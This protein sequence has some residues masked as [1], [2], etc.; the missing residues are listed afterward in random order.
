MAKM[1][2]PTK[3]PEEGIVVGGKKNRMG[4]DVGGVGR[5]LVRPLFWLIVIA[6]LAGAGYY[7]WTKW[8]DHNNKTKDAATK[9]LT[10]AQINAKGEADY[11]GSLK[12]QIDSNDDP[13]KK[14]SYQVELAQEYATKN[15]YSTALK[16]AKEA[17]STKP[18]LA[19]ASA[20]GNIYLDMKDY[21]NA[22]HY[23]TI[24][25]DRAPKPTSSRERS[26]YNDITAQIE[27]IK[28]EQNQ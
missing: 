24:A 21:S 14:A 15:D 6:L 3:R 8:S 7:G 5:K 20:I 26:P 17:E 4:V 12:N 11:L 23:L 10:Q 1:S 19:T 13:A 22:I 9:H 16:Y 2:E 28:Q 27:Q 25:R 18:S